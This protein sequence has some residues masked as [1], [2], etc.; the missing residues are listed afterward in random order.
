MNKPE[1]TGS[2][3][4]RDLYRSQERQ[5]QLDMNKAAAQKILESLS[6]SLSRSRVSTIVVSSSVHTTYT[7]LSI[8]ESV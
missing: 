7:Q 8:Y 3:S 6:N 2:N 4:Y 5:R 1:T